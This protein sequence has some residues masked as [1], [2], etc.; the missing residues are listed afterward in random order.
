MSD[1]IPPG[2]P[3]QP[4]GPGPYGPPPG[5]A[6]QPGHAARGPVEHLQQGQG[7]PLAPA[8]RGGN[9]RR[10]AIIGGLVL[11]GALVTGGVWAWNA[12]F[13]QG[14]QPAEALPAG[15]LAYA[16]IDLD[17]SGAQKVEA[18]RFLRKFP[19]FKDEIG[20]DTDDDVR[21][22]I[23]TRIQD[24]GAC[25]ELDYEDDIEPWLG[26]RFA[27]AAVDRGDDSP[28]PVLVAQIKDEDKAADGLDKLVECGNQMTGDSEDIGGYAFNG[29][30]VI[31]AETEAIA[32][33]VVAD[34]EDDA[35]SEDSDYT[36]WTE[37]S[38]DPGIMT[39]YAAPEAG[40]A[41]VEFM[42]DAP[43][44]FFGYSSYSSGE[45]YAYPEEAPPA[46]EPADPDDFPTASPS[47]QPPGEQPT[48]L[49]SQFPTEFPTD[50]P[51][52]LVTHSPSEVPSAFQSQQAE[53]DSELQPDSDFEASSNLE[54]LPDDETDPAVPDDVREAFADFP[55]GAGTLRFNDGN[56]ELEFATGDL[57][58]SWSS[59]I[60]GDKGAD[61]LST[62]PDT[63][64]AALGVGFEEGWV[65]DLIDQLAPMI[66]DESGMSIDEAIGEFESETGLSVPEDIE[67]LG[68]ESFAIAFDSEFDNSAFEEEDI[69]RVPVGAKIKGDPERIEAALDKIRA[70]AGADG[71]LLLSRTQDGYV[72]VSASEDYLDKLADAGDLGDS[73]TLK[74]LVPE[75]DDASAILFVNFDAGGWLDDLVESLDAPEDVVENVEP[76]KALG[77]SN[78]TDGDESHSLLKLT[79]N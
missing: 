34:A 62:L 26:D 45:D 24:E 21:K 30:W 7:Q 52:D 64:A 53:P 40:D 13:S 44:A 5:Y 49:P 17:P 33:D 76:L 42:E 19:A 16:S 12:F 18:I 66:E 65:D 74:D 67:A 41:F 38:G 23:F 58:G 32:K 59:L 79:T 1:N 50:L 20:L 39:L 68:G 60:E 69:T 36:K 14:P 10:M 56:L 46:P 75:A 22:E 4:I 43:Q 29:D 37:A 47:V 2:D 51:S 70:R 27:F 9:G 72:L 11:T 57:P 61:V 77:I 71:D 28:A 55:G 15:T 3:N 48:E 63:T 6:S 25:E 78:W 31:L 8:P 73:S 54:P 35:L